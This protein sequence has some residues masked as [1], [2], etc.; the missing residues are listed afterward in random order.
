MLLLWPWPKV[1]TLRGLH[2][3]TNV[4]NFAILRHLTERYERERLTNESVTNV[5]LAQSLTQIKSNVTSNQKL[6]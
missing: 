2:C 5:K 6:H 4:A 3:T 1:I